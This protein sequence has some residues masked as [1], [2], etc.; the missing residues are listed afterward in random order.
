MLLI[1]LGR[2]EE[3]K[4]ERNEGRKEERKEEGRRENVLSCKVWTGW[5]G[6]DTICGGA[7][8]RIYIQLHFPTDPA[9]QCRNRCQASQKSTIFNKRL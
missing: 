5:G 1:W 9:P 7:L 2:K 8:G 6:G 4:E 3:G